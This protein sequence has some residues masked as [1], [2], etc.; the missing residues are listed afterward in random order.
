[1]VTVS[2]KR[3]QGNILDGYSGLE[4]P[5]ERMEQKVEGSLLCE[6]FEKLMGKYEKILA[7]DY[8]I[9]EAVAEIDHILAPEQINSFLQAT[10]RHEGHRNYSFNSGHFI[11]KLIQDSHNA[12]YNKFTLNTKSLVK[13]IDNIGYNIKGKE[14]LEIIIKGNAGC[15]CGEWAENLKQIYI[16]GNAGKYC[17]NLAYNIKRIYIEGN[18]GEWCGAADNIEEIYVAGSTGCFSGSVATNSTFKTPN[19]DTLRLLKENVSKGKG[20]K[21]YFINPDGSELYIPEGEWQSL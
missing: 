12:G 8:G 15:C 21:L 19:E 6:G 20:N 2:L 3:N 17:G 10:I 16:A 5:E 18:A 4:A 11:T 7:I 9:Q 1:M 13:E 14:H